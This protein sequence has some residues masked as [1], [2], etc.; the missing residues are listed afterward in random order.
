MKICHMTSAHNSADV[1]VFIKECS[2]LAAAGYEVYLVAKGDSREENGVRIIG[3]GEAP[4]GRRE[5]MTAFA[6]KVYESALR[7]D[8]DVYHFH[9]PE[10]LPYGRKLKRAG[11]TVVYDI[12]EST[13]GTIL[14]KQY[15]P[16]PLRKTISRL[17]AGYED[18]VC[19]KL[20]A[21]VTVTPTQT[22]YYRKRNPR[23]VEATNYPI[24][25]PQGDA[26][27]PKERAIAFAG[28]ITAQWNHDVILRAI[29]TLPDCAY[30]LCGAENGYLNG[31]RQLDGWEQVV[32]HGR[33]A[34]REVADVLARCAVGVALLTPGNNTAGHVGTM[35]NTKIFEEMMA[36][37][38]VVCTDFE[39]WRAFVERYDCGIC[40]D[41]QDASAVAGAIRLLLD[42]PETAARMGR[43]ARRAVEQEFN[44]EIPKQ[45]L[46]ALYENLSKE[47]KA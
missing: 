15:I 14:E 12:H 29:R 24:L 38:P 31:L 19:R 25:T 11:K 17:Y 44:W 9:D 30:H 28:G 39:L 43:N 26:D 13:V 27:A 47:I 1:R 33:I 45:A 8:C 5:R 22:A 6:R 40:V 35:G 23:T 10:L 42:D 46:L 36:G 3:L 18:S 2:S 16:S 37:L 34:H 20:D 21:L 41:P 4:K 7:L 32:Y